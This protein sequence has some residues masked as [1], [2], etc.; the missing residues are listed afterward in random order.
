MGILDERFRHSNFI[1]V[2]QQKA[3]W[4]LLELCFLHCYTIDN[5]QWTYFAHKISLMWRQSI[6]LQ[7][8]ITNITKS[9]V[10]KERVPPMVCS[11]CWWPI[12]CVTR[13]L[14]EIVSE[15]CQS[16]SRLAVIL[17]KTW[18]ERS[19]RECERATRHIWSCSI[20]DMVRE[21]CNST[22]FS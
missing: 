15:S 13:E 3:V 8:Y 12:S 10:R 6:L 21:S 19:E 1:Y 20:S 7:C 17:F 11:A 22:V 4:L 5:E 9:N 2:D 14:E 18:V 16:I